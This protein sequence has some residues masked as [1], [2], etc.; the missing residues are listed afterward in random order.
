MVQVPNFNASGDINRSRFVTP[1][2]ARTVAQAT[3]GSAPIGISQR[4]TRDTPLPGASSLAAI[5]D[6][7][8]SIF[9]IGEMCSLEAGA[10][11][12]VNSF[13]KPDSVGRGVAI[14]G[15]EPYYAQALSAASAAGELFDVY[16]VRGVAPTPT[17]TIASAGSVQGDAAALVA[18]TS[19]DV[20]GADATKGVR[21]PVPPYIGAHVN[22]YSSAATN[23]LKVYPNSG[24]TINNGAADAALSIAARTPKVF[25]AISLT[26]WT[27][28]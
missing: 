13:V 14:D 15:G 2:G 8:V 27:A 17:V 10:A 1:S 22:V 7:P 19:Y 24:A 28:L 18:N 12:T 25:R 6:S 11:V 16:I 21:L 26:A 3:A 5:A 9:G 23:V 20:T 4:G